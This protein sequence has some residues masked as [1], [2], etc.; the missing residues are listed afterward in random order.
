MGQVTLEEWDGALS[1]NLAGHRLSI[2]KARVAERPG[3]R[4]YAGRT[5]A[6]G[7]RSED[8]E[9]AALARDVPQDRRIQATVL[10]TEVLG[11]EVMAR[12]GFCASP[13]THG[14]ANARWSRSDR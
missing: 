6:V 9:D 5:V 2:D 8:M 14:A 12:F 13:T 1:F 3:L 10:R 4:R 11:S 7:V